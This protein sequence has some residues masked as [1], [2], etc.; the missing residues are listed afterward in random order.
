M[1]LEILKFEADWCGPCKQQSEIVSEVLDEIDKDVVV[2]EVDVD[3]DKETAN[4]YQVRSLP[5]IVFVNT[6]RNEVVEQF[7]GLTQKH[8]LKSAVEKFV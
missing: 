3:E 8:A 2:T 6:D 7:V 5:T 4:K 1:N